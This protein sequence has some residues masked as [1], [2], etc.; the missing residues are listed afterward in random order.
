MK[1]GTRT[2]GDQEL[3]IQTKCNEKHEQGTR[4]LRFQN[5][6]KVQGKE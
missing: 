1:N 2:Q 6:N 4:G 3:K 5:I